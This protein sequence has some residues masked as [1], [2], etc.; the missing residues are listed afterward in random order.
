MDQKQ[1]V[2]ALE[3][4]ELFSDEIKSILLELDTTNSTS[5]QA[6]LNDLLLIVRGRLL[7]NEHM[8]EESTRQPLTLTTY[9]SWIRSNFTQYSSDMYFDSI[10]Q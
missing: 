6:Y 1:L 7:Q 8:I 10:R 3:K 4:E 9:E 5:T 2:H